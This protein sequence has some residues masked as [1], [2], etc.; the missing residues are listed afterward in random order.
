MNISIE[1]ILALSDA[2]GPSGF[3]EDVVALL[4]TYFQDSQYELE[5]DRLRNLYVRKERKGALCVM[6]D[7]HTDEVG[8][9]VQSL[10]PKGT[11]RL[12]P[13]GGW[14]SQFGSL[15]LA[16]RNSRGD[17]IAGMVVSPP[18]H[19]E[20][21]RKG[22]DL[23]SV[24]FDVGASSIEEVKESYGLNL[25]SPLVPHVKSRFDEERGKFYGK[26][27]DCR[28]GCAA[29][30]EILLALE[31]KRTPFEIVGSFSSQEE[32]GHRGAIV[33]AQNVKPDI[34]I[35]FEG[36]PAD[37]TFPVDQVQCALGRGPMLRHMDRS[38]ITHPRFQ[39][40]TLDI[41]QKEGICHQE[42]V[43]L[44]GGTNGA[45]IHLTKRGV[46]TIVI[47]IPVRYIHSGEGI[48]ALSDVEDA[49]KLALAVVENLTED[50]VASF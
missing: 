7:A 26:A 16:A 3:E 32:V 45:A 4:R 39:R 36:A 20:E 50:I 25:G 49:V 22:G 21:A 5:E 18:P 37:D 17:L 19:F 1:R 47:G 12:A 34:A 2:F 38:M 23:S 48:C 8:F 30:V 14:G 11:M 46:P 15:R 9:M 24:V 27:F 28:I 41:A 43:R 6:L 35:T 42:A 44:G 40:F 10:L 31:N 13:L 33:A 29:L